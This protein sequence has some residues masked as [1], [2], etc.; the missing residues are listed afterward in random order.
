MS[1]I[2]Q[3]SALVG[4]IYDAALDPTRWTGVLEKICAFVPGTM[5][6][7]FIQDAVAKRANAG[8][9]WGNDPYYEKLYLEKLAKLNPA[10]PALLFCDVGDVFCT[11]DFLPAA[12][13]E[14]T[15]FFNEY[16]RPQGLGE[17]IGSVLEKSA[18]SCA[19]LAVVRG[20]PL[21]PVEDRFRERVRL[22]VPHV[23]RAVLIGKAIDLQKATAEMLADTVDGLVAAVYLVDANAHIVHA[24]RSGLNLIA[25][26]DIL[27]S[28]SGT[29]HALDPAADRALRDMLAAASARDDVAVGIKG[30]S[31]AL[32]T[33]DGERYVAHVLPLTAGERR[34]AG[35]SYSAAAAIFV[36]KAALNT[37][38]FPEMIAKQFRLTPAEL[39]VIF[40][41]IEVGGVPE[42]SAVLGLSQATIKTHLRSIFAKTGTKRQ[43]DLVKFVA[44]FAN[45][46]AG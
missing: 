1:E 42:V 11:A 10:F 13:M 28:P 35:M 32:I 33:R 24:N 37:A 46:T 34:Q 41:I 27:R 18:T 36:Q 17:A 23:Q 9:G 2:D 5:A 38:T 29:L 16:L 40:A 14:Q 7:I 21:G 12:Q 45:P 3:F 4:D 26:D 6:N 25:Q 39:G 20:G 15:R 31:M 43:A 19:V 44:Q 22:V 8:F 30:A